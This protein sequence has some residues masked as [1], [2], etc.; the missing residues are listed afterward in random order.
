[1]EAELKV[2]K[3]VSAASISEMRS[4]IQQAFD[5]LPDKNVDAAREN[6]SN[7]RL[8]DMYL[9]LAAKEPNSQQAVGQAISQAANFA[10]SAKIETIQGSISATPASGN[11]PL[12][13]SFSAQNVIDPSGTIPTNQD[14]IWWIREN[15]GKRREL[16]RGPSLTHEFTQEGTY[17]V[18]LDV[19][20]ASR[21]S[22]GRV[23]VLPLSTS[24]NVQ[25]LPKLGEI[26]LL[27]N[28][29]NVSNMN[30]IKIT[31]A[32][33]SQ[34]LIFDATASRAIGNGR[35][36]ETKWEFDNGNSRT[37]KSA[38][39]VERQIFATAG[40]Y[41][42]KL[43]FT[44]NDGKNFSK[45]ITLRIIDPAA[46]I[47]ATKTTA[48]AGETLSFSAETFFGN[49][50]N[51]EYVWMVQSNDTGKRET[52]S[53]NGTGFS[54]TFDK[55]GSYTVTLMAKSPNGDRD[56]DSKTITVESRE[57]V[58]TLD[59]PKQINSEKPNTFIFDASRS[60][61][62]DTNTRQGLTYTWRINGELVTLDEI[63]GTNADQKGSKG[64]LT[65]DSI[66]ENTISVTVSN[67]YGKIAT[68]EQKF[69]VTSVLSGNMLITPQVTQVG[70]SV[71]FIAQAKNAQFYTWN[72]GDG[73]PQK[74][75]NART[76]QHTFERTGVYNVSL[77]LQGA[78]NTTTTIGRKVY[79]TDMDSPF[80]VIDF[81]NAS[82]SVIQQAGVCDGKDAYILKR[83]ESTQIN[84]G[85]SINVDG[86]NSNLD[87]TWQVM[88]KPSTL[89]NLSEN[90]KDLGCFPISLTVKSKTNGASHT[91]VEY[92]KLENQ[93]PTLTNISTTLDASKQDSQKVIVKAR[94]N[95]V[96]DPDGVITSYI[97]YYTTASD[98][99]PQGLQ[100]TQKPEMTFVLP[101]ITEK[102][103]FGVIIEDNDGSRV[104]SKEILSSNAPL[105]I[106][107]ENS[108]VHLPLITLTANNKIVK[109]GQPVNISAQVKTILGTDVTSKAQYSWDFDGDGRIDERS[110]TSSIS[111]TFQKA[112]EYKVR[113]RV[114][115][116]GVSNTK[117]INIIVRNELKA[118]V[119][120]YRLPN[121][122]LYLLNTSVGVYDKAQWKIGEHSYTTLD[123]I[124]LDFDSVPT[125]DEK[126]SIGT[127]KVWSNDTENSSTDIILRDIQ[128]VEQ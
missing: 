74:A 115:N 51:V 100:I 2:N 83:G 95:G 49:V 15:G 10:R 109:I 20:S 17:T 113:V 128:F 38:P 97:W 7:K 68:A 96:S 73:S 98:E 124:T 81:S 123:N 43:S 90:F 59:S 89:A 52:Q 70:K 37:Y 107:N 30:E 11:A 13:T 50:K 21:N 33:A 118:G 67:Q 105:I 119:Q 39:G 31:P 120:G 103:Y 94:A 48:N 87:Y 76:I 58:A 126:G 16:G 127:L 5:R 116:N 54:Y 28:G 104:D 75:G 47:K 78:D 36:L 1:M 111:H 12:V 79:V 27:I 91:T 80:A 106:D 57:P 64:S 53:G 62:P 84:G 41:N 56:E 44:T 22:K 29:I 40:T 18:N 86:S 108:N 25:V 77:I 71:T 45:D 14:Y 34:G 9:D 69:S 60:F 65:F 122:Q 42:V 66:G 92:I 121:D 114:T 88:G 6:E 125:A 85:K 61:D 3:T 102:Y 93:L 32:I 72:M 99:E 110:S 4:L 117:T 23:D 24:V 8:V 82:N 112:G 35:I 46:T 101:N 63:D 19:T 26:T 55:I